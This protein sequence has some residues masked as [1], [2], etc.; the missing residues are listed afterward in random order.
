[1]WAGS[2]GFRRKA[3]PVNAGRNFPISPVENSPPSN[4]S[5]LTR[6]LGWSGAQR[7]L[8]RALGAAEPEAAPRTTVRF[9]GPSLLMPPER[10]GSQALC[11]SSPR[12]KSEASW[13]L[14]EAGNPLSEGTFPVRI[15]FLTGR[16]PGTVSADRLI[17]CRSVTVAVLFAPGIQSGR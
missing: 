8:G 17:R 4:T 11:R 9:V 10:C 5:L 16:A 3:W 6:G 13:R 7:P 1:M 12:I 14:R 2:V 15:V